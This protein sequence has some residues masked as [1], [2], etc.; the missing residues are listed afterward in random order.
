MFFNRDGRVTANIESSSNRLG[1]KKTY[2]NLTSNI[3]ITNQFEFMIF[4]IFMCPYFNAV[5]KIFYQSGT[6][7]PNLPKSYIF[8]IQISSTEMVKCRSAKSNTS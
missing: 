6:K 1:N 7:L 8:G 3:F 2:S 4:K 5:Q